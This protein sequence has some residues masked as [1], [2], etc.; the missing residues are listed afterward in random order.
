MSYRLPGTVGNGTSAIALLLARLR[1]LKVSY[2]VSTGWCHRCPQGNPDVIVGSS[3]FSAVL[4]Q[5]GRIAGGRSQFEPE[6]P[7]RTHLMLINPSG[8]VRYRRGDSGSRSSCDK[9]RLDVVTPPVSSCPEVDSGSFCKSADYE[10]GGATA[11]GYW[12]FGAAPENAGKGPV[13]DEQ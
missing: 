1:Q 9:S 7:P 6:S 8:Y 2:E 13:V 5:P 3:R 4:M 11:V 12:V 10:G